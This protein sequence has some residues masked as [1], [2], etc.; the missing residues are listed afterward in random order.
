[1]IRSIR[2]STGAADDHTRPGFD[3][4]GDARRG[5]YFACASQLND[6]RASTVRAGGSRIAQQNRQ[7]TIGAVDRYRRADVI[8]G[9][10]G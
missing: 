1:M 9:S 7:P 6:A 3:N 5:C 4:A 10:I 2:G 8:V